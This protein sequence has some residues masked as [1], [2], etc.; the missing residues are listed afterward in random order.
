MQDDPLSLK[1]IVS[2]LANPNAQ[3]RKAALDATIQFGSRDA[4]PDLTIAADRSMDAEEKKA[5]LDAIE[6]LKLP[7]LTEV[8][9][10]R[11]LS[12]PNGQSPAKP[13][14]GPVGAPVPK[15]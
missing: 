15:S 11:K 3:I 7:S 14:L 2:E 9:Q 12:N 1:E 4:I 6:F 8:L 10:Q 13:V 5:I